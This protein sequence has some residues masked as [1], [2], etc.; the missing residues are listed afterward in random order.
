MLHGKEHTVVLI[1]AC[2]CSKRL[3]MKDTWSKLLDV[4]KMIYINYCKNAIHGC[5]T[6]LI[7]QVCF[8]HLSIKVIKVCY[9]NMPSFG[10]WFEAILGSNVWIIISIMQAAS[11]IN[12]GHCKASGDLSSPRTLSDLLTASEQQILVLTDNIYIVTEKTEIWNF[13]CL[14]VFMLLKLIGI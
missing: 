14:F 11:V 6:A 8:R 1:I 4:M 5:W 2:P 3:L 12:P 10:N 9:L 7:L 13:S